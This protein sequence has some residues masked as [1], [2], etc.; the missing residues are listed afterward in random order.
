[1][2]LKEITL[3]DALVFAGIFNGLFFKNN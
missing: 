3:K 2:Q 1:M